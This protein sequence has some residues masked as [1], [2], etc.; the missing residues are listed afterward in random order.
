MIGSPWVRQ[1]PWTARGWSFSTDWWVSGSLRGWKSLVRVWLCPRFTLRLP[2]RVTWLNGGITSQN[3]FGNSKRF[4][5]QQW[6]KKL[7]QKSNTS[8][9]QSV[10]GSVYPRRITAALVLSRGHVHFTLHTS[11]ATQHQGRLLESPKLRLLLWHIIACGVSPVPVRV[12]ALTE[13]GWFGC[14]KQGLA[15]FSLTIP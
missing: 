15:V 2:I 5:R 12:S 1:W 13:A 4:L 10:S 3:G 6:P 14:G 7:F 9:I 11:Y 8:W